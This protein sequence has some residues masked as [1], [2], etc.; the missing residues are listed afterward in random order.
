VIVSVDE[1]WEYNVTICAAQAAVKGPVFGELIRSSHLGD[2]AVFSNQR[3]GAQ[4]A[5][6]RLCD[7]AL[8]LDQEP[9]HRILRSYVVA[10]N[11]AVTEWTTERAAAER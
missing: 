7:D 9:F 5:R 10:A 4:G 3:A 6:R 2:Q 8:R 1:A 11:Q